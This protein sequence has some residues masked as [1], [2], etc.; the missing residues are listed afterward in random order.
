MSEEPGLE[1]GATRDRSGK[2]SGL[3]TKG[4][5][6]EGSNRFVTRRR[7][8][9]TLWLMQQAVCLGQRLLQTQEL[10]QQLGMR[11]LT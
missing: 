11:V 2:V 7:T 6:L 8:L 3:Q 10:A 5:I 4:T 9:R 1:K